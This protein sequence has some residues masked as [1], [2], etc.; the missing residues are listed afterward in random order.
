MKRAWHGGGVVALLA[1]SA[2][3]C[4][5]LAPQ[6]PGHSGVVVRL[7]A[8]H[9]ALPLGVTYDCEPPEGP[10]ATAYAVVQYHA[11]HSRFHARLPLSDSWRPAPGTPVWVDPAHCAMQAAGS[12]S[13][14]PLPA[15]D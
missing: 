9:E 3:A 1:L 13:A 2:C 14:V 7:L 10:T 4:G 5:R 12:G 15:M 6:P 8:P 11:S